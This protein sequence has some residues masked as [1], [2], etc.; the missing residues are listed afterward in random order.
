MA[1]NIIFF[2]FFCNIYIYSHIHTPFYYHMNQIPVIKKNKLMYFFSR[3][4]Q[5]LKVKGV[6]LQE[7][8]KTF[9]KIMSQIMLNMYS[10]IMFYLPQ[11][12][13]K[14]YL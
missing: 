13:K 1:C 10:M 12:M 11:Q 2:T 6:Y 8:R 3:V 7:G 4:V 9:H 5:K 14:I